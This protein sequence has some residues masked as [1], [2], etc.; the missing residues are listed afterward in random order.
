[1]IASFKHSNSI[2]DGQ[3]DQKPS[4][5]LKNFSLGGAA[6][7]ESID[8]LNHRQKPPVTSDEHIAMDVPQHESHHLRQEPIGMPEVKRRRTE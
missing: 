5:A 8:F 6:P 3:V 2:C 7:F 1:M 4:T